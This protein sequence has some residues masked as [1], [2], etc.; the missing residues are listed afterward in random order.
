MK[1]TMQ[2]LCALLVLLTLWCPAALSAFAEGRVTYA[3]QAEQFIFAPGSSH[4][5]SDLFT[6]YKGVMPGDSIQQNITVKNDAKKEVKVKIYVR[7]LGSDENS[8]D[9]LSKLHLTVAKAEENKMAYMFDAAADQTDGMTDWVLLG[10]LYSGGEVNLVLS[11]QVPVEL[12]NRYQNAIGYLD[13]EFKVEELPVDPEDPDAPQTGDA[14]VT[15]LLLTFAAVCGVGVIV[16][17]A[18]RRKI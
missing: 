11:L 18:K 7:S 9:L 4:S 8:A 12:D 2:I 13:W 6:E 17:M 16:Y 14:S 15:A 3:G 10:T 5:P 1:K